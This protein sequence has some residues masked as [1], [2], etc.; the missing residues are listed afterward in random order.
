[1]ISD[2]IKLSFVEKNEGTNVFSIELPDIYNDDDDVMSPCGKVIVK[3]EEDGFFLI[4]IVL[5]KNFDKLSEGEI[6]DRDALIESVIINLEI[7]TDISYVL[8]DVILVDKS[9]EYKRGF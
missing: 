7:Q 3:K 6:Y 8:A 4:N 5:D 9:G 1:M 2:F